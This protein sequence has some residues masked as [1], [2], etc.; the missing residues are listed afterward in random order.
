MDTCKCL[1]ELK[2]ELKQEYNEL[3]LTEFFDQIKQQIT[4]SEAFISR[5]EA[6]DSASA[7]L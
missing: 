3:P 6:G 1:D 5:L 2:A 4:K 7:L